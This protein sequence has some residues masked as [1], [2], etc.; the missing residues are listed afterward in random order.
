M[1]IITLKTKIVFAD[2]TDRTRLIKTLESERT[3]FN[4][5]S[6][7]QF[8]KS[9]NSIVELHANCYRTIRKQYPEFRSQ[10]VIKAEN[11]CLSAYKTIKSNKHKID[12]PIVKKRL[13]TNF[14]Q[15]LFL[16]RVVNGEHVFRLTTLE[17]RI[18]CKVELYP[19]LSKMLNTWPFGDVM[20]SSNG[21]EV[22]ISIGF[23]VETPEPKHGLALGID[24]GIRRFATTSDGKLF[25]DKDFNKHK[26][27]LRY[28]KRMLRSKADTGSKTAKK[29]LR[30]LSTKERNINKDFTHKLSNAILQTSCTTIVLEDLNVK[31]LK[32]K[33]QRYQNKNRISQVSFADLKFMVTYKA[34]LAGKR[35]VCVS[36]YYT[37]QLDHSTGK[38]EGERIGCRFYSLNGLVYDADINAAINI[39][40][41]SNLP[42]SQGNP[43]DGQGI[44]TNPLR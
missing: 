29:H 38:L 31:Q 25:I 8:G 16:H 34:A 32:S 26:R 7:Y 15:R 10:L 6:Q 36:P 1:Q 17:K 24:L 27:E 44:V 18:V 13:A 33:R 4:I 23:K 39:A 41:R 12:K 28:L 43:L 19:K 21:H 30:K 42:I 40:K 3:A 20:V 35:V 22:Y 11:N 9:R 2:E 14:D 37:S 5:C